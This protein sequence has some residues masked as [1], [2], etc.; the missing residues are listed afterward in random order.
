MKKIIAIILTLVVVLTTVTG[1]SA[2]SQ[3]NGYVLEINGEQTEY[4]SVIFNDIHY[5]PMRMIFEKMGSSVFYRSSDRQ[6]LALSKSGDIIRHTVESNI[7]SVNGEDIEF[8]NPSVLDNNI[9]YIPLDMIISAFYPEILVEN[10]QI[11]IK[12]EFVCSEYAKLIQDV[13]DVSK[14]DGFKPEKFQEYINYHAKMPSYSMDD[15]IFRVNI[16]LVS[17][18]YENIKTIEYPNE[19]LVLVNKYNKLPANFTQYNLVDMSRKYTDGA[20]QYLL[21]D[22]AYEKY[23]QMADAA[24]SAG[25]S[26]RVV[27]SYR[28]ES[29]QAGLYNNK[30][31]STGRVN[32]DNYSARPG[33]SEH[34]TGLAVD[35]NSTKGSFEYTSEFKWL[36]QHAHEYGFIMRYP[37]GKEW[38]TGYAY[39]PWHYRFVGV[40]AATVIH[41]EGITYEEYYAK[42]VDMNE[43]R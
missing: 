39:E 10:E 6:I 25:L 42:Y 16:G 9:T 23:A 27:S 17:P 34:Q 35:I 22:T 7:V 8:I 5:V 38:I 33:H 40:D 2:N 29:Y 1:G 15:V 41:N 31:Y 19:L 28:T 13:L 21:V 3:E 12:K 30:L 18:F 32:A 43:Y 4:T 20:K 36:Q 26:M 11:N 24:R 37:R 14:D